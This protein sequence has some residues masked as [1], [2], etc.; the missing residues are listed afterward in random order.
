VSKPPTGPR[1]HL[2]LV[3]PQSTEKP[4][5]VTEVLRACGGD[6]L[7]DE[8]AHDAVEAFVRSLAEQAEGADSVRREMLRSAA[9]GRLKEA[10]VPAATSLVAAAF[11]AGKAASTNDKMQGRTMVLEDPELWPDPVDGVGLLDDLV[12][13]FARFLALPS[14]AATVL[15]L[16]VLHAHAHDAAF[17]S[18]LLTLTSPEKRCGKS[19]T[20]DVLS[21]LVP[22]PALG[23]NWSPAVLFRL[24]ERDKPTLLIDEA[25]SFMREEN[26]FRNLLNSGHRKSLAVVWRS[27]GEDFEPR[28]FSTWAPKAIAGIGRLSST[29][30][31]RSV[32]IEL[33][34]RRDDE[35]VERLRV[36]RLSELEPLRQRAARW[37]ADSLSA[38]RSADPQVPEEL[39]DRAA[40]NWRPLLAIADHAGGGW[41]DRAR[42]A[43]KLVS[44]TADD[45]DAPAVQL[46]ADIRDIIAET[47]ADKLFSRDIKAGL[48]PREDRPWSE[49]KHGKEITERQIARLLERFKITPKKVRIGSE[50][51]QG[52]P[53]DAF[54]D[55]FRRYLPS[56]PEHPEQSSNGA[57]NRENAHRNNGTG[58]PGSQGGEN[59]HGAYDV[60]DVPVLAGQ[61]ETEEFEL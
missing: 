38:L 13:T 35:K 17:V 28:G 44:G 6:N 19:T 46:L 41:A 48:I 30:Q 40:D 53:T 22:R 15:A 18:P 3:R 56:G 60:P 23:S 27:V 45:G 31:D 57:E 52:Y 8:P 10:G 33:R 36:D 55:A 54:E 9:I 32:I 58:V 59:P 34:R 49:W 37:A 51:K 24:V 39:H 7:G 47:G 12:R 5:P 16:W 43:A 50:T 2:K 4:P 20:L 29:L 21:A 1:S 26:D 14:G 25:D 61:S 11:P 42:R